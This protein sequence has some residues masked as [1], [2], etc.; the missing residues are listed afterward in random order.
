MLISEKSARYKSGLNVRTGIKQIYLVHK[1][2]GSRTDI[3]TLQYGPPCQQLF[4]HILVFSRIICTHIVR[5]ACYVYYVYMYLHICYIPYIFTA[6]FSAYNDFFF[7]T[8]RVECLV[9]SRGEGERDHS[10]FLSLIR[11]RSNFV[12]L[13][14]YFPSPYGK[15]RW[16]IAIQKFVFPKL[17]HSA[18]E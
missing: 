4:N 3:M 2:T 18:R 17:M 6:E 5:N 16:K 8:N 14:E 15:I 12:A 7:S 9:L 10:E 13:L 11:F 1:H